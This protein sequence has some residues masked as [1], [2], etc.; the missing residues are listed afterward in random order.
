[1]HLWDAPLHLG[2]L[3]LNPAYFLHWLCANNISFPFLFQPCQ[4][5]LRMRLLALTIEV[6]SA[7]SP[8]INGDHSLLLHNFLGPALHTQSIIITVIFFCLILTVLMIKQLVWKMLDHWAIRS[9]IFCSFDI[10][11]LSGTTWMSFLLLAQT[12]NFWSM[13]NSLIAYK[14]SQS[15]YQQQCHAKS[16]TRSSLALPVSH[17][18]GYQNC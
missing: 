18:L 13:Y 5:C 1:M 9:A 11:S 17:P 15:L 7:F 4:A 16:G 10:W 2:F 3:S 8:Y 14:T 6:S 12:V